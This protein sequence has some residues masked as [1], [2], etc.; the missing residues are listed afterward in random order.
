MASS[1]GVSMPG[2][3]IV[4]P[5]GAQLR[6]ILEAYVATLE[7][8]SPLPSERE[9]AQRFGV[10]RMTVRGQIDQMVHRGLVYRQLRRGTF[11]AVPRHAH[12]EELTTFT[13]DMRARGLEPGARRIEV[14]ELRADRTLA[15]RMEV[16]VGNKVFRVRRVRTADGFPMALEESYLPAARFPDVTES[17]FTTGS[18]YEL[19]NERYHV[20]VEEADVRITVLSLSVENARLLE[21]EA[22]APAFLSERTARERDGVLVE[23]ASLIYRGDRYEVLMHPRRRSAEEAA[24]EA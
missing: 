20:A 3:L 14:D 21:T 16:S 6:D 4:G 8:G 5:K 2:E 1:H 22:G 7:P 19:L 17:D 15:A 23:F 12:T 10:A 9:L 13:E 11:V 24:A 18:L